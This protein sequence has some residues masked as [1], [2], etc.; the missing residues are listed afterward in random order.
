MENYVT[1]RDVSERLKAAR[2]PQ[3]TQ[4]HF[5]LGFDGIFS[6]SQ[7]FDEVLAVVAPLSDE[8]MK[9]LPD[10]IND[11]YVKLE[12]KWLTRHGP[13]MAYLVTE[14]KELSN[15]IQYGPDFNAIWHDSDNEALDKPA[16]A[17]AELWLWCMENGYIK[18]DKEMN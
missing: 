11:V 9:Q 15:S 5:L 8:L 7:G 2:Y 12:L 6:T 13:Y 14:R 3:K 1:S 18:V 10:K 17:L 16:D 4:F